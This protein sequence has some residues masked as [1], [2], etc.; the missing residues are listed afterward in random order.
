VPSLAEVLRL[1]H[2]S[3]RSLMYA[4]EFF[5]ADLGPV[6]VAVSDGDRVEDAV[7]VIS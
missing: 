1:G 5:S 2:N 7:E 4:R 3:R 6:A